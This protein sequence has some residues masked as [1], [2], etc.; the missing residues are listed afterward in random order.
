MGDRCYSQVFCRKSDEAKFEEIGY[1]ADADVRFPIVDVAEEIPGTV[2]MVDDQANYGNASG[3]EDLAK[4]GIPFLAMNGSGGDYG[5]GLTVSDGKEF[6]DV[7]ALQDSIYPAATIDPNGFV[8]PSEL[9]RA[10]TYWRIY[11]S[12]IKA[13]SE[14]PP[15]AEPAPAQE[16]NHV[17]RS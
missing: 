13:L 3:L 12:A 17:D 6:A 15:T 2:G 14:S 5:D 8:E 9:E 1:V 16:A 10:N 7:A 4:N 11:R